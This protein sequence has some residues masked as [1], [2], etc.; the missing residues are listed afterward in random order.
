MTEAKTLRIEILVGHCLG[1]AGNDVY[2]GQVLEAPRD[3]SLADAM[4]KIR[5]GYARELPRVSSP[6]PGPAASA[7]GGGPEEPDGGPDE[8]SRTQTVTTR[9]PV[10]ENRDPDIRPPLGVRKSRKKTGGR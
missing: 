3:L 1:G 9:D 5:T 4:A 7:T 10:P 2:P 6:D 8:E